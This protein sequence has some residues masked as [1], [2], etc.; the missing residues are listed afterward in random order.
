[1]DQKSEFSRKGAKV[2]TRQL[3][4]QRFKEKNYNDWFK[5]KYE[6]A[7]YVFLRYLDFLHHLAKVY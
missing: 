2:N 3:L 1:M 5:Y 4:P 6:S 7:F